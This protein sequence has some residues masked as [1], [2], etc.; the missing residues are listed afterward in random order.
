MEIHEQQQFDFL[1]VTAVERYT[2]RLAYRNGGAENALQKARQDWQSEGI[3]LDQ[4]VNAIFQ[5]FLLDNIG[6]ACFILKA[7]SRRPL[8]L[9]NLY[10]SSVE[11][12][13]IALA[14]Q[15]FSELFKQK[16]EEA[17]EQATLF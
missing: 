13:L 6:G 5:D 8:T 14:K 15:A 7:L 11:Q 3:W 4:F 17:L 16:V 2:E 1:M 9:S 10:Q 12:L